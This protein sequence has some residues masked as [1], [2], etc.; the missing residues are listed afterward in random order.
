MVVYM[1]VYTVN[2]T[3]I[4]PYPQEFAISEYELQALSKNKQANKTDV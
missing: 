3:D 2:K 4:M 1:V